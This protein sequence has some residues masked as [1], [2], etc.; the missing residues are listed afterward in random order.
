MTRP[1]PITLTALACLAATALTSCASDPTSGYALTSAYRTDIAT[2]AVPI[3]QNSTYAHGLETALTDA[4]IK[5]IHRSTPWR[6]TPTDRADTTLRAVITSV[7]L[8]PMRTNPDSGLVQELAY[9]VTVS[10]E[11]QDNRNGRALVSR[12]GF[13]GAD[14]FVPAVGAQET[15]EQG[16]AATADQLARDIVASLRSSW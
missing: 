9:S 7:D 2:I 8:R 15:I 10:F 16:Q 5:E 14:T 6:V 12:R 11:W 13:R 1:L 3:F 4:V